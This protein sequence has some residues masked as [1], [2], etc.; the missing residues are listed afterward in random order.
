MGDEKP[1]DDA[2]KQKEVA[3][4]IREAFAGVTLGNGV[5]LWWGQVLD[6]Y[7]V[8]DSIADY[9]ANHE[10]DE[11]RQDWSRIPI[12]D[13]ERCDTSLCFFDAEGMRFHL[14]AFMLA[15]LDGLNSEDGGWDSVIYSLTLHILD[16]SS[17]T[18]YS[19][20][21]FSLLDKK[22][23]MAVR[24]FLLYCKD[25][26]YYEDFDS[27]LITRA[28]NEYWAEEMPTPPQRNQPLTTNH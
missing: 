28:L 19:R 23:W 14:P 6:D 27:P 20:N 4:I 8:P 5:G 15:K 17:T 12:E 25:H 11:E 10:R 13:L 16:E 22:Q 18:D 9:R 1:T 2:S 21:K 26:P 7:C 24:T 3:R